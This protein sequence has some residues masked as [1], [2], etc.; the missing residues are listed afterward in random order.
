MRRT[1]AV[2][3]AVVLG[4]LASTGQAMAQDPGGSA[5]Q[6]AANAAASAQSALG[7]AGALQGNPSNATTA[8]PVPSSSTT[9]APVTSSTTAAPLPT[10]VKTGS[11]SQS[12]TVIGGSVAANGNSTSQTANQTQGGGSG[13]QTTG[14]IADNEQSAASSADAAQLGAANQNID[15]RVLSPGNGGSVSQA[16]T[17]LAGSLAGNGNQTTQTANQS[18]AGGPGSGSQQTV[19]QAAANKQDADS[20]ADAKQDGAKNSNISVRIFSPGDDGSVEQ[21]NTV[22]GIAAALNGNSTTQSAAQD[23]SGGGGTQAA[24]QGATS[25]QGA[26]S[27]ADAEQKGATN[28]NIAVRIF[29][30]G[31]G[32]LGVAVEH[33]HRRLAGG[34]RERDDA[35]CVAVQA[36]APARAQQVVGQAAANDQDAWSDADATQYGASNTN[37]PIRIFSDGDDGA[38]EQSNTVL[39]LSAAL[40]GNETT[41]TATQTQSGAAP[42]VMPV[43]YASTLPYPEGNDLYPDKDKEYPDKDKKHEGPGVQAIGQ[44]AES[45]QDAVAKSDATQI[46]ASNTNVPVRIGSTGDNGSVS[47]SNTTISA[48]IAANKNGTSQAATQTQSGPGTLVQ[49]IGQAAL[50]KQAC[51]RLLGR[52]PEGRHEHEHA[53]ERVRRGRPEGRLQ[54]REGRQG[55]TTRSTAAPCRSRT[56]PPR[57]AAALNGNSTTQ[58]A[59]QTQSGGSPLVQAVAQVA[60]NQQ[61]A[62]G[63]GDAYQRD[64]A[65]STGRSRS[66]RSVRSSRRSATEEGRV[67]AEVSGRLRSATGRRTSAS[68]SLRSIRSATGR[69]TS[70]SRS[71]RSTRSA[72]WTERRVRAEASGRSE[73]RLEEGRVRVEAAGRAA[74]VRAP[75]PEVRAVQAV[76]V[77]GQGVPGE[78]DARGEVDDVTAAG[79]FRCP[80]AAARCR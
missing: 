71:I 73:V 74:T 57:S 10:P 78:E 58:A 21:S 72:S 4:L 26:K 39:G 70:A 25:N 54:G 34:E 19:G 8:A 48:A 59:T 23:S 1:F 76:R 2:F 36:A 16:N 6:A 41:Q 47:Q 50:S 53:G 64:V 17:V 80:P 15:V 44:V 69:R 63:K 14:Q 11:V 60:K 55:R 68:P 9:P 52:L 3:A 62:V 29:S 42:I 75:R 66:S 31:N 61:D 28:E 24:L 77:D 67:Q 20:Y 35:E 79:G 7:L 5:E 27:S 37:I 45:D 43:P 49:A 12:N 18:Q 33:R 46:G 51:A 56:R 65:N 38:V 40:N 32:R 30:P 13:T 22:A